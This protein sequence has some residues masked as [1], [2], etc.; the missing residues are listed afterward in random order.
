MIHEGQEHIDNVFLVIKSMDWAVEMHQPMV[1]L[2]LDFEKAYDQVEGVFLEG[3]IKKLG[4]DITWVKW[5]QALFIDSLCTVG[6]N[7]Q[8]SKPF[9]LTRSICQGCPLA[10]FL[11]FFVADCLGY[12]L[13]KDD[14]IKGLKL[15]GTDRKLI[16]QE[17][18][19]DTN[20]YL[21]G[22]LINL[23]NAKRALETF[24][25]ATSSKINW[26]KSHTI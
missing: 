11:Y 4:F 26:N 24:S 17:Y 16:D 13:E 18:A 25:L 6:I 2:L 15:L 23:N 21:E 3:S 22:S 1:M 8:T 14:T 12:M 10:P 19:N 9:Q 5:V 20:L 7:S